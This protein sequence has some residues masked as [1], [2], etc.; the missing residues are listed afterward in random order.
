MSQLGA[1]SLNR[2]RSP[3]LPRFSNRLA[4]GGRK[5]NMLG[6]DDGLQRWRKRQMIGA[7]TI[8][9]SYRS[10]NLGVVRL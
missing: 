8:F 3:C 6:F 4:Q 7:V 5:R 1:R 9:P 10:I 2:R